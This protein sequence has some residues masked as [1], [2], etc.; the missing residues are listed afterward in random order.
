MDRTLMGQLIEDI[1]AMGDNRTPSFRGLW[2]ILMQKIC[3]KCNIYG[4]MLCTTHSA[5]AKEMEHSGTS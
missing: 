4:P 5:K 2:F 1:E 3:Q